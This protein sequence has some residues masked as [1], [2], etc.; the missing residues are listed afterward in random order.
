MAG[1]LGGLGGFGNILGAIGQSLLTSPRENPFQGFPTA[2]QSMSKMGEHQAA[3]S[4]MATVAEKLGVPKELAASPE[5]MK[6]FIDHI[7]TTKLNQLRQQAAQGTSFMPPAEDAAPQ[8]NMSVPGLQGSSGVSRNFDVASGGGGLGG[9]GGAAGVGDT[10]GAR[11]AKLPTF[12]AIQGGT[13]S[14]KIPDLIAQAAQR[15]GQDPAALVRTAQIESSLN[16]NAKNPSSSAGGLFQFINST[17][18]QYG[19][20]NK[21]DP[22]ASADAGA[23][24][25][26]DNADKL[27]SV[28]GR[29][30]QPWELYLAHQQG[31]A[32]AA[33]IL[34]N[35]NANAASLV[36]AA[37]VR[38]NGGSPGMT[39]QQFA[40]IWRKKF[41]DLPSSSQNA[42]GLLAA[43]SGATPD[44]ARADAQRVATGGTLGGGATAAGSIPRRV[45]ARA[46]RPLIKLQQAAGSLR[47]QFQTRTFPRLQRH[48][49]PK[50][51]AIPRR[52]HGP[53][54]S[55][56]AA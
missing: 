15:Y 39:A 36:G 38:L 28:L 53:E 41:G 33:K 37:S 22:A 52:R 55:F 1:G 23:R 2:L 14:G 11:T 16:P 12:A 32:G 8:P 47:L 7:N 13:P 30:P 34:S 50:G 54:R 31:S 21:F 10:V 26:R 4:A 25:M 9:L 43:A 3:L 48:R 19:L 40:G 56:S 46:A 6:L 18:K 49:P 20:T 29:D 27:R 42:T 51:R 5:A 35:P 24:L 44:Y 17:A 45:S